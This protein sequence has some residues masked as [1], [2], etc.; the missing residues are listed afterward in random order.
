MIVVCSA[1][2]AFF[3]ALQE[4]VTAGGDIAIIGA[5]IVVVG[6]AIIA[7]LKGGPEETIP[8]GCG[9]AIG[10]AACVVGIE[11]PFVTGFVTFSN[12]IATKSGGW[13]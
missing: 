3:I 1:V 7:L 5:V 11:N 6:V 8:T 2:I 4:S 12:A 9:F 13:V 10:A